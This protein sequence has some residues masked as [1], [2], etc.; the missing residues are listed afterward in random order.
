MLSLG[1]ALTL[2]RNPWG[3]PGVFHQL[4]TAANQRYYRYKGQ[5]EGVSIMEE[6]WDNLFLL[7]GCRYDLFEDTI[8]LEGELEARTS[9]GSSSSSDFLESTFTGG[10]HLDMV[11]VTANPHFNRIPDGTFHANINLLDKGGIST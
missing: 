10:Q 6:D 8:D 7:D 2:I 11:Y 5:A 1:N 9:P 4:G 3:I